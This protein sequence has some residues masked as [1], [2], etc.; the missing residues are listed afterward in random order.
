MAN[1]FTESFDGGVG[2]LSH[3]WGSASIDAG[4]PGQITLSGIGSAMER[5]SGAGAGHGYGTYTV[6]ASM[7]GDEAG[8]AALLWPADDRWPGPEFDIVEVHDGRAYGCVHHG[9]GGGDAYTALWYDGIDFHRPVTY[10]LD[11]RPGRIDLF[12]DGRAMGTVTEGV[13]ADFAHGGVN[14][15]IGVMN[16]SPGTSITVHEV[17]YAESGAAAPAGDAALHPAEPFPATADGWDA[18]AAQVL[19]HYEATGGW[20]L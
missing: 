7:T 4:V 2:A 3:G 5:P 11:W 9:D 8:P 1:S 12:V 6:V 18:V 16:R 15:V 10:T 14:E 20:F 17:S 19:A 13:G